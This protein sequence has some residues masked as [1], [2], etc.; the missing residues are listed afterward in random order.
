MSEAQRSEASDATA[1]LGLPVVGEFVWVWF[2]WL[3]SYSIAT[4]Q[5]MDIHEKQAAVFFKR[6]PFMKDNAPG[7]CYPM[8]A[9]YGKRPHWVPVMPNVELTG[10]EAASS[11][12]RPSRMTC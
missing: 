11:P 5:V 10:A 2:H 7:T 12:E 4:G 6:C 9:D 8:L 1:G 3:G